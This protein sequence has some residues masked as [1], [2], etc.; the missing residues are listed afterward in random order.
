MQR[1]R[2]G[3]GKKLLIELR[4]ERAQ[5]L[6]DRLQ[7]RLLR[8]RQLS[9]GMNELIVIDVEQ[10]CLLGGQF[11]LGLAPVKGLESLE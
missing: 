7:L 5:P 4:L 8:R 11:Q 9:A 1:A 2:L 3:C 10:L 6:V